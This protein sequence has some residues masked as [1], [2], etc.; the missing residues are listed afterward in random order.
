MSGATPRLRRDGRLTNQATACRYRR[1]R[2]RNHHMSRIEQSPPRDSERR[3]PGTKAQPC[4]TACGWV[5]QTAGII[6]CALEA[7]ALVGNAVNY[8]LRLR[9]KRPPA[10]PL[11]HDEPHF[12]VNSPAH[13]QYPSSGRTICAGA[14]TSPLQ[15]HSTG[16][17]R[18]CSPVFM[19]V[20]KIPKR[21]REIF[22]GRTA[23]RRAVEA[24]ERLED[25][26]A[27]ASPWWLLVA[28]LLALGTGAP[29]SR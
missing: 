10:Y 26:K 23:F 24:L 21:T 19:L 29:S 4:R 7:D 2:S 11:R 27:G 20:P 13:Q 5:Q 15:D 25:P 28:L 9:I 8:R 18:V 14:G 16:S 1:D 22:V 6:H 17:L 3:C 12:R